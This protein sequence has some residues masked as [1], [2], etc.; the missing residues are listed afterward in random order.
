MPPEVRLVEGA[1]RGF[2]SECGL[3]WKDVARML[4]FCGKDSRPNMLLKSLFDSV[5]AVCV[6]FPESVKES[7]VVFSWSETGPT[8]KAL[9]H[10]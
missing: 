3:L 6:K 9:T 7:Q 4:E 10:E 2:R 8:G 1:M 5:A